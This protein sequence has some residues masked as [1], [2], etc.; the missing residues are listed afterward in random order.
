MPKLIAEN[1]FID[2]SDYGRPIAKYLVRRVQNTS[3]TP[4]HITFAFGISGLIASYCILYGF[5]LAALFFLV[6]KSILDAADGELSRANNTPSY[7]GRYLDSI[8]DFLL[9]A[10]FIGCIYKVTDSSFILAI[11]AFLCIQLQGT[12]YNYYYIILRSRSTG[13]D[14]TSKI[15]E[16]KVPRAFPEESQRAVNILFFCFRFLYKYFD[17]TVELLDKDAYKIKTFPNWFMTLLSV[18][19]IGFQLLI[20]GIF[21]LFNQI[22]LVIP[23]FIVY[24]FLFFVIIGIRKYLL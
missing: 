14:S 17:K 8:F 15:F 13:G 6:T 3:V 16:S 19:G 4:I 11:I 23:F 12:L 20:M 2:L 21:I 7:S 24:S 9:N 18:Y 22:N 1:R 10:L 5:N